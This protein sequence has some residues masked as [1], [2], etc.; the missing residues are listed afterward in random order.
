M[1]V[2]VAVTNSRMGDRLTLLVAT[3]VFRLVTVT[4]VLT[5]S[6]SML[7]K[8]K[9]VCAMIE[10]EELDEAIDVEVFSMANDVVAIGELT[11]SIEVD[12]TT[13]DD[14]NIDVGSGTEEDND[15]LDE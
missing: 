11:D 10:D 3:D 5:L 15:T 2:V 9:I 14:N 13:K 6:I 12:G 4:V 8:P 1:V 7:D